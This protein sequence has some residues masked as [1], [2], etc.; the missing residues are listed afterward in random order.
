MIITKETLIRA[1]RTFLQSA[2]AYI[3]VNAVYINLTGNK[4]SDK[5]AIIG[6]LVSAV[7]AGIAAA[8]NLEKE[9]NNDI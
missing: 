7:S 8:M 5:S 2:L 1:G 6:L 3:T 9:T 4:A